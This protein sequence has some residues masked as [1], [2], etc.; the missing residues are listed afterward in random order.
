MVRDGPPLVVQL[1]NGRFALAPHLFL[2][3]V[4]QQYDIKSS[5]ARWHFQVLRCGGGS[6][7]DGI[8]GEGKAASARGFSQNAFRDLSPVRDAIAAW[9]SSADFFVVEGR[10]WGPL[11]NAASIISF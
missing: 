5:T 10:L 4:Y 2:K 8:Q 11:E 3:F 6:F 7:G 1:P 9:I